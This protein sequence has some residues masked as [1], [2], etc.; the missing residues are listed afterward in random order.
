MASCSNCGTELPKTS[1]YC[2]Q[3]GHPAPAG[4]TKEMELPPDETGRVPVEYGQVEPRYYGVTPTTLVLVL[5][6]AA[7]T[8]AVVL[9]ALGHWPFGLIALGAGVLLVLV[10]LEAARRKPDGAVA[11]ST[12]DALD[13][14]RTRAGVAA[15]SLATRGR[16]AR[17]LLALRRELQRMGVLRAR[18][19]FQ[20][21]DAVYR[22]DD[23]GTER[24]R[25]QLAELDRLAAL[26][27][28]EMEAVVAQTQERLERRRLEV[29]PTEM[30]ELPEPP[31]QPGEASPGAPAVIPEPYPPPDEGN[32]PEPAIMPEPG[33]LGPEQPEEGRAG[34]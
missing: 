1:R 18:L 3:C 16:A 19:L 7:L 17:R 14:F 12:A 24:A 32:P 27:E 15:G 31:G 30:V 2:P 28:A 9:F 23:Q 20:L 4:E 21:G 11:R 33:P 22:G 25:G 10:F 5:A 8:L 29:Q 6:G 26:M 13:G 34:A